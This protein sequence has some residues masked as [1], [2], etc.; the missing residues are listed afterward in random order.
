MIQAVTHGK[1]GT[2]MKSFSSV[3]N[4]AD[5]EAVVAFVREQFMRQKRHNTQYH[6]RENGWFDHEKYRDAFPFALGEI[7]LDTPWEQLNESQ[8]RG[9]LLFMQGCISCHDR[10]RVQQEGQIWES[11][12]L[13]FP[14]NGYSHLQPDVVSAASP[15]MVHDRL[16]VMGNLSAQERRGQA[17][18]QQNCAFCHA[19][20]G[21]GKNWIGQFIQPHPRD[22]RDA[23]KMGGLTQ[24]DLVERIGKG[25]AG[26][27]MPAWRTVLT[28][29]QLEDV[30]AYVLRLY[31]ASQQ[32][33]Q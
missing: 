25:V 32:A 1:A 20:N 2:A 28:P 18:F 30:A 3:L 13:S 19:N 31:R 17:I 9:R 23:G 15:Y 12:P 11:R 10:A 5:V 29:A 22:F 7:A 6:T 24:Q 27:A 26:T 4:D 16:P 33:E 21:S 8:Q 14:R